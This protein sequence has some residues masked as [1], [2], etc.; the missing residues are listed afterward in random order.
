MNDEDSI[1]AFYDAVAVQGDDLSA[2]SATKTL[3]RWPVVSSLLGDLEDARVLDAGCG[4]GFFAERFAERGAAVVGIDVSPAMVRAANERVGD[5]GTFLR[6]D[7]REPLSCLADDAFDVVVCQ[8]ALSH[9]ADLER[10]FAEFAR[11]LA[12]VGRLV[13]ST[14]HPFHDFLVG[15]DREHP[16]L[17][18]A[19][20]VDATPGSRVRTSPGTTGSN[21]SRSTGR[22][23][24]NRTPCRFT[25]GPSRRSSSHCSTRASR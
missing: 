20:G 13:V 9:L 21:G 24:R 19:D 3:L 6:A 16:D 23:G 5:R 8:Y 1:V 10:P 12:D 4:S 25:G 14:H 22:R 11:V 15:R 17:G 2:A 18:E 7:L